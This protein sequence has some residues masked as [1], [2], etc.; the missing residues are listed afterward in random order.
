D[1]ISDLLACHSGQVETLG[2]WFIH[3][4]LRSVKRIIRGGSICN[5]F[6]IAV[7]LT[8]NVVMTAELFEDS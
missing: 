8:R 4:V 3:W 6:C 2:F 7:R 1:E 5:P